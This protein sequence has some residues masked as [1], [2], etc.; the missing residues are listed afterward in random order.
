MGLELE[1]SFTVATRRSVLSDLRR[2]TLVANFAGKYTVV[3]PLLQA[4]VSV[5]LVRAVTF[6][7]AARQRASSFFLSTIT[8]STFFSV[9]RFTSIWLEAIHKGHCCCLR[10]ACLALVVQSLSSA[11]RPMMLE[12]TY[13]TWRC[14]RLHYNRTGAYNVRNH[15]FLGESKGAVFK[16][17]VFYPFYSEY[18]SQ[19]DSRYIYLIVQLLLRL[20]ALAYERRYLLLPTPKPKYLLLSMVRSTVHPI[21]NGA[22]S[23]SARDNTYWGYTVTD[24]ISGETMKITAELQTIMKST[25]KRYFNN[26]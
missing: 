20:L 7:K 11:F 13:S 18:K 24:S 5:R 10:K 3:N 9:V 26:P 4:V 6:F 19:E 23:H 25:I 15:P 21:G 16:G 12:R 1:K 2:N 22:T 17:A 14:G 8:H